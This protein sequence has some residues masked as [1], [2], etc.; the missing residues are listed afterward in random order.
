MA[1]FLGRFWT[2]VESMRYKDYN[3]MIKSARSVPSTHSFENL[4]HE[5]KVPGEK[6]EDNLF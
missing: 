1:F 3:R 6:P 2:K 4:E 5:S